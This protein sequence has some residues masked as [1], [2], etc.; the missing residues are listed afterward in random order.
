MHSQACPLDPYPILWAQLQINI[1]V[2]NYPNA[3]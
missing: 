3:Y 2:T 1:M